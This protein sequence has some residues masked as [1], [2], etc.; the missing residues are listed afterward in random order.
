MK[1]EN[2]HFIVTE[3]ENGLR[4]DHFLHAR[5]ADLSRSQ[6]K[7]LVHRITINTAPIKKAGE[8]VK[9]GDTVTLS[10]PPRVGF[11]A[12]PEDIPLSIVFENDELLV[13]DKP[14]GL[15]VHPAA[16]NESG[17]LLNAVLHHLS[18][19]PDL[20]ERAGI[21]HRLDK[22]TSGL[23]LIAKTRKMHAYLGN[24]LKDHKIEKKYL[25]LVFGKLSPEEGSIDAPIARSHK[26]RKK[27]SVSATDTARSALTHYQ[28]LDFFPEM[29]AT[30]V[31]VSI[32]TGRTHQIRV[33]FGAIGFPVIGD[34]AY[35]S[36]AVNDEFWQKYRLKRQ[37]LHAKSL[38]VPM[39]NGE[40][41]YFESEL[42][43]E[44]QFVLKR[45]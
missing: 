41:L 37:F 42:P 4:I 30:L 36:E 28:V 18:K 25:A 19:A 14:A 11:S 10:I 32:V 6:V 3:S 21:V 35:G 29:N 27:M 43:Q 5:V 15:V 9:V 23:L 13:I 2:Y 31:E 33:H 22:D 12:N 17:T 24:L 44:L 39:P 20:P 40:V 8:F 1:E 34:S 7:T 16:G 26:D 45:R 38:A